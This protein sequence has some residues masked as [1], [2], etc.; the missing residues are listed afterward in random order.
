MGVLLAATAPLTGQMKPAQTKPTHAKLFWVLR[1]PGEM[2]E[3]DSAT[4]AV[5]QTIKVPPEA[6]PSPSSFSVNHLGQI[7][8]APPASLPLA[9]T[10]A[11]PKLWFWDGHAASTLECGVKREVSQTGSN[12]A[13]TESAPN[14]FLSA[15]GQHLYWF[16]NSARRLQRDEVDLSTSTTWQ[17]WRTDLNGAARQDIADAKALDC[18]CSTGACEESCPYTSV[19]V[20]ESG[21]GAFFM[22][23]QST[24][25]RTGTTYKSSVLY[26]EQSGS[27][28]ATP[29]ADP[30]HRVLDAASNGAVIVDAI[31]DT[32][33]CGWSNQS[34]DQ[35]RVRMNGKTL[36]V[37]DEQA[38]YRNS[39]Y[40]VSF[41]TANASLSP[42]LGYVAMTIAATAQVNQPIQLSE[43]GQAN[44]EE[45]KQIRKSLAELPAVEVK[46]L[47]DPPRRVEFL[48]HA[49]LVGWLNEKELLVLENHLLVVYNITAGTRRK[50]TLRVEDAAHVFLR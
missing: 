20:P 43:Q 28:K 42:D 47:S 44:P 40:D 37:F 36:T 38:T 1:S 21:V 13:I 34:N 48:P 9:D 25:G 10:D 23:T 6:L 30:L 16:A 17:A 12:Q 11:K 49:V 26:N 5:K 18:R 8:F 4:F 50:S 19:W 45:S 32:G 35:T 2:V 3:Y 33:C 39:D 46:T 15:D 41:F 24:A 7:L 31:P 27:W 14:P 29:L 22:T